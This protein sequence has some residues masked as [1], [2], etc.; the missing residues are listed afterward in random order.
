[1]KR[2][3]NELA[4][5]Y[6]W[7]GPFKESSPRG[8][9]STRRIHSGKEKGKVKGVGN[10]IVQDSS[11]LKTAAS[12][13]SSATLQ[14][15]CSNNEDDDIRQR[16]QYINDSLEDVEQEHQ[17]LIRRKFRENPSSELC[18]DAY[19]GIPE[20]KF[21]YSRGRSVPREISAYG[22][23]DGWLDDV[24]ERLTPYAEPAYNCNVAPPSPPRALGNIAEA[25]QDPPR[26]STNKVNA[27]Q[28]TIN[29]KRKRGVSQGGGCAARPK[30]PASPGPKP[31]ANANTRYNL[32]VT[33]SRRR[34]P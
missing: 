14:V 1:M 13:Q 15:N 19:H 26:D 29:K 23:H 22:F 16:Q 31:K 17:Q 33:E 5:P 10:P 12:K 11:I 30:K 6:A 20:P 3:A 32:R 21:L 25:V 18:V 4:S 24:N 27:S 9:I 2:P 28:A 8:V 34:R 7:V